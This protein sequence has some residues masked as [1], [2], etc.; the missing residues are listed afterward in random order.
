MFCFTTG[1]IA[2]REAAT[3]A[4]TMPPPK[5]DEEQIYTLHQKVYQPLERQN[6]VKAFNLKSRIK[7]IMWEHANVI[8]RTKDALETATTGIERIRNDELPR[9]GTSARNRR[10]N[11]EWGQCLE[12]ENMITAAAMTLG[13]A[14]ARTESR[15][16]H[17]RDDFPHTDPSWLKNVVIKKDGD[18][19]VVDTQPVSFPVVKPQA[20]VTA[21]D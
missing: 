9:L 8:G 18:K 20:G 19:M 21:D 17:Y 2:G 14:L 16:L 7:D 11:L 3:E 1:S 12:I 10:F 15:G 6:G 13:G 5:L 4:K